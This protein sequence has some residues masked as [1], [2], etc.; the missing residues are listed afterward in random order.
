MGIQLRKAQVSHWGGLEGFQDAIT[1]HAARSEFFE[2]L[3]GLGCG[4]VG[5]VP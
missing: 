3:D 2:E 5:T 4:H 1:A